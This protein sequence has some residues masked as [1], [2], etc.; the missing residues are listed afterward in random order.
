M[1]SFDGQAL[2][3]APVKGPTRGSAFR[4]AIDKMNARYPKALKKR[5]E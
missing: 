1:Q 5:S 4:A 2:I 3:L